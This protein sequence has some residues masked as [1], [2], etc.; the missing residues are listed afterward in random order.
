MNVRQ[1]L[2]RI[3]LVGCCVWLPAT[4]IWEWWHHSIPYLL[5]LQDFGRYD[6]ESAYTFQS[7]RGV[8]LYAATNTCVK[9]RP[10]R[11]PDWKSKCETGLYGSIC[12]ASC[13]EDCD[14]IGYDF[15]IQHKWRAMSAYILSELASIV[16]RV[17]A[18]WCFAD[19]YFACTL[20]GWNVSRRMDCAWIQGHYSKDSKVDC[21]HRHSAS[22]V[23]H[24]LQSGIG[25]ERTSPRAHY[26][27]ETRSSFFCASPCF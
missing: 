10:I 22:R 1:G 2:L 25:A 5:Y 9:E 27:Q 12:T 11:Y 16:P 17:V 8:S 18:A 6:P 26:V 15:A 24:K 3:W 20:D 4:A 13:E 21:D 14:S 7:E 23:T 19:S